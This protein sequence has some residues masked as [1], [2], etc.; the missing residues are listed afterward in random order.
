MSRIIWTNFAISEFKNIFLYYRMIA[1]E[2]IAEKIRRSIFS[3]TK[4]LIKQPLLGALEENL[5]DLNQGHRYI[6]EGNYKIIY[7]VINDEIYITDI[8][9]CRQNPSKMKRNFQ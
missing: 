6:I 3:A 4:P 7:R 2:K 8:F 5:A 9:D 1:G